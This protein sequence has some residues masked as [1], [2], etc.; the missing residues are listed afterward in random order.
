MKE[1]VGSV[2]EMRRHLKYV[3]KNDLFGEETVP[4]KSNKRYFPRPKTI[5]NHM[6]RARRKLRR[7]LIDQE[8]LIDKIRQ[9]K[10]KEKNSR[11]YFRP[12]AKTDDDESEPSSCWE[13]E[14]DP[15]EDE[16]K[17]TVGSNSL[18]FV[19]QTKWQ[20]RL[21]A[22]YG[23][24]MAFLDATYRTTR[25]ALP[26][27]FLVVKTNVDYQ[28]AGTFVCKSESTEAIM[29]ALAIFKEWNPEFSPRFFM[30]DYCN[31]EINAIE[32]VFKGERLEN[33]L[34]Q[35]PGFH[36]AFLSFL[37][38]TCLFLPFLVFFGAF[39]VFEMDEIYL[40]I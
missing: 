21:L 23:N 19:Y 6:V 37:V 38:F 35:K 5:R 1:G 7:S 30:T 24:E 2:A 34:F 9:W 16:V 20:Q 25:Y 13:D 15:F 28:I 40:K 4:P 26:L 29:E 18:L 12:K 36:T 33:K 39:L 3:V 11:F 14:S 27:F 22:R 8:C 17:I 10:Q 32:S 31:E